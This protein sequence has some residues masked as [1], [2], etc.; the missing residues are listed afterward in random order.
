MRRKI[1]S[2]VLP[3]LSILLLLTCVSCLER[4]EEIS[5]AEDGSATI[6][7]DLSGPKD[8]FGQLM[9]YPSEPEWTILEADSVSREDQTRIKAE[10][11]VAYGEPWPHTFARPDE[12]NGGVHLQFP[13]EVKYWTE[14]NRTYYEFKRVYRQRPF[15]GINL[16]KHPFWDQDLENR[17]LEKGIFEASEQDR[18]DYLEQFVTAY[19]YLNWRFLW[20]T[21]GTMTHA[22]DI[23]LA[24]KAKIETRASGYLESTITPV[25][26][27]GILGKDDD[28]MDTALDNLKRELHDSFAHIFKEVVASDNQVL[29]QKYMGLFKTAVL[30]YEITEVLGPHTFLIN[31]AMP[32]IVIETNGLV[33]PEEP[34]KIEWCFM[35]EDLYDTDFALRALSVVEH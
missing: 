2:V 3:V 13:S 30:E 21:L 31:L 24:Q 28:S 16:T 25:R 29:T 11:T 19:V 4:T 34:G 17:V 9:A 32:G 33:D 18:E 20:E 23:T 12:P 1:V 22:G 15:R 27:L 10:K 8:T 6:Q 26:I 35:G 7:I 5:I 14:G